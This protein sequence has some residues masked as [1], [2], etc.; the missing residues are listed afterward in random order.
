MSNLSESSPDLHKNTNQRTLNSAVNPSTE[1]T[2]VIIF[3]LKTGAQAQFLALLEPVL[4]A[5]RNE[6]TFIN[7]I[8]HRDPASDNTFML[9]ETWADREDVI[10]IQQHRPYRKAFWDTLPELLTQPRQIQ[11][12]K[13]MRTDLAI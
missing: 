9:Y 7:A 3:H 11:I 6:A 5:M 10:N 1:E 13:P 8:L 4:D 12:W 2:Y